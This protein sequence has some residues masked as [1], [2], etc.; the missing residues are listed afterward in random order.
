MLLKFD[1][2]YN[3]EI[4]SIDGVHIWDGN[5][6]VEH[7][8]TILNYLK[9]DYHINFSSSFGYIKTYESSKHLNTALNNYV[10]ICIC[11]VDVNPICG[12]DGYDSYI[13]DVWTELSNIDLESHVPHILRKL[14]YDVVCELYNNGKIYAE[15]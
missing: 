15:T 2:K 5:C 12:E 7:L 8:A 4:S 11:Y 1:S 13:D 14:G 10:K 9:L 6:Y 3:T